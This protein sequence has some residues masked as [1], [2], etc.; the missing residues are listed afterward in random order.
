MLLPSLQ[1][2]TTCILQMYIHYT[3]GIEQVHIYLIAKTSQDPFVMTI[4]GPLAMI[5]ASNLQDPNQ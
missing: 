2:N 3:I 4:C 5:K 1:L